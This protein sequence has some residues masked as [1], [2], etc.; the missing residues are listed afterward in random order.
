MRWP[1]RLQILIPMLIVLLAAL[2]AVS[3]LSAWLSTRSTLQRIEDQ[4]RNVA[5]TLA[6]ANFPL[7]PVVLQQTRGLSGADYVV[8]ERSG[9][10]LAASDDRLAAFPPLRHGA[11]GRIAGAI[12]VD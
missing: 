10:V 3:G 4:L 7:G 12:Q 1:L 5:D 9:A 8:T 6:A 11:A 2:G